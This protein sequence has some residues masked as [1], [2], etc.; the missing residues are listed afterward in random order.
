MAAEQQF[1]FTQ[2]PD[3]EMRRVRALADSLGIRFDEIV[4]AGSQGTTI[5]IQAKSVLFSL[6]ADS[7]TAF[8]Q[9]VRF[10]Q[11]APLGVLDAPEEEYLRIAHEILEKLEIPRTEIAAAA[12]QQELTQTAE[13]RPGSAAPR[14]EPVAPG[15]RYLMLSRHIENLP[16]WSSRVVLGLTRERQIGFL[17]AHWPEIP[18][19]AIDEATRLAARVNE[20]FKPPERPHARVIEVAA[21]V[22]HSPAAGFVMD[23][24]PAIRVVYAGTDR[25]G[26]RAVEYLDRHGRSVPVPRQFDLP[27]EPEAK[28]RTTIEDGRLDLKRTRFREYL[29]A[30][31]DQLADI[32]GNTSYE[33]LGCVGY[34][35]QFRRLEAVV[36]IKRHFG[37]GGGLC[38]AGTPEYVR[39]Y[40]SF[41]NGATWQDQGL[42]SFTAWDIAFAGDRLEYAVTLDINPAER[43][44][45][46]ANLPLARAI[47]AWNNPPPAHTPNFA[48]HW[49]NAT[50]VRIQIGARRLPIWAEILDAAKLELPDELA[51]LV[52]LQQ[53]TQLLQKSFTGAELA[54]LYQG[55]GVPDHR[56]LTAELRTWL[57]KPELTATFAPGAVDWSKV[58]QQWLATNGDI[59]YEEL[60]CIGL[61]TVRSQLVGVI[62]L[63]LPNGYSGGLCTAGSLEYVGF[64]V[65][66]GSGYSYAGTTSVNV[67]DITAIPLPGGL[68]YAIF[69]P[70]DLASHRRPCEQGPVTANVRAIL[71]WNAPP[72]AANPDYVPTWGNRLETRVHVTPGPVLGAHD[73]FLSAL[74]DVG[75]SRIG[76]DGKANGTTIHTGLVCADSPFGG[77]ITIAGHIASPT[78][79]MRYRIM[80]KLNGAPDSDYAPL[81]FAPLSLLVNTWSMGT[82]WTQ[83]TMT[84]SPDANGYYP[85]ED[86]SWDHSVEGSLM[87]EWY[88]SQAEDG[89]AYD[90]RID[91]STDGN[92]A[93]DLHS[94]VVTV[95]IDN[96]SPDVTLIINLAGGVTCADFAPGAVFTGTFRATDAHFGSYQ[97]QILPADHTHGVLPVPAA[98]SSTHYGGTIADPGQAPTTFTLNTGVNPG[99]PPTGPMDPCGYALILHAWDRTNV[100]SGGGRNYNFASAGF[101]IQTAMAG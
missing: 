70:I 38:S 43:L 4:R 42:T 25:F 66:Y 51:P 100:N 54:T 79:G 47:L 39:F 73:P 59:S 97:F 40:L 89:H 64:W 17:E 34:Q 69:L 83:T 18:K 5:G 62:Q 94:N 80:R 86:Y 77:R 37:Y 71:S 6:R 45:L 76:P 49:G 16:I 93:H 22:I 67:H 36:Y 96:T 31:P 28:G 9:D 72:P 58:V 19:A 14:L 11:H 82:G 85:Y 46:T 84:V 23:I 27:P 35:P 98:G 75:E 99:S 87:G 12:L 61:D 29:L 26:K 92:P 3:D 56:F 48:P 101:C 10:G 30:S 78:S 55:K 63:K 44:C 91:V 1:P 7:R 50:D 90:L 2:E 53:P 41:D 33:E 88:S 81:T 20:G 74:G 65:D 60:T 95:L 24:Y 15:K 52:D 8:V 68:F 32:S 21:G 57:A 13:R